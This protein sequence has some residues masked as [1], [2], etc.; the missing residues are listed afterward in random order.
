MSINKNQKFKQLLIEKIKRA[1]KSAA[2]KY[3]KISDIKKI[4]KIELRKNL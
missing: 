3:K 4:K 2:N 1:M